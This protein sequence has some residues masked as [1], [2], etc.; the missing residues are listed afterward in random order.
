MSLTKAQAI[1]SGVQMEK[2]EVVDACIV[3]VEAGTNTPR[4]GDSS[5]GGRTV[6]ELQNIAAVAWT[7]SVEVDARTQPSI[8]VCPDRVTLVFGGD[9]EA[10]G[11]VE[12]LRFAAETLERQMNGS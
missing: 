7:V 1:Q 9:A 12:A 10:R 4:G 3:G 5:H 2:H 11:L 8:F 6:L